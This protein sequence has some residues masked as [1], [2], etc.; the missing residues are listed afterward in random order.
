MCIAARALLTGHVAGSPCAKRP[1]DI[2][3]RRQP[4]PC[5]SVVCVQVWLGRCGRWMHMQMWRVC[6]C[7]CMRAAC[8]GA[9]VHVRE[10]C[11]RECEKVPCAG[12]GASVGA[13]RCDNNQTER[14]WCVDEVEIR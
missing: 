7:E 14:V 9:R 4:S 3:L 6:E 1:G 8:E 2:W 10:L 5:V 11:V 12:E 13:L